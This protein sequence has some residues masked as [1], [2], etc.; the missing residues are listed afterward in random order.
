M[1]NM[2]LF[3]TKFPKNKSISFSVWVCCPARFPNISDN[4]NLR[5]QRFGS[6]ECW[7][8]SGTY[9][10]IKVSKLLLNFYGWTNKIFKVELIFHYNKKLKCI[11]KMYD[12]QMSS[13][14]QDISILCFIDGLRFQR[15]D[16]SIY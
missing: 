12:C 15:F 8:C 1:K 7:G 2:I 4:F 16:N 5:N 9:M 3:N 11:L 10:E 6:Q 13:F 14:H